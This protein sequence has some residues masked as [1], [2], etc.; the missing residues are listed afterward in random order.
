MKDM[1]KTFEYI[2]TKSGPVTPARG[3]SVEMM[4]GTLGPVGDQTKEDFDHRTYENRSLLMKKNY[5]SMKDI[6]LKFLTEATSSTPYNGGIRIRLDGIDFNE[7]SMHGEFECD[8]HH[9]V[10]NMKYPNAK[11]NGEITVELALD[12][13]ANT[14]IDV[15][16]ESD[17]FRTNFSQFIFRQAKDLVAQEAERERKESIYGG[18]VIKTPGNDFNDTLGI[19]NSD[20]NNITAYES[21]DWRLHKLRGLC[22]MCAMM[23]AGMDGGNGGDFG[24]DD[25]AAPPEGGDAGMGAPQNPPMGGDGSEA[26]QNA[27]EINGVSG[28]NGKG[29]NKIEFRD[30]A[31]TQLSQ[32]ALDN[33]AQIVSDGLSDI[34]DEGTSGAKPSPDEWYDGFPGVK[35]MTA[36]EIVEQFLSFQDYKAL[37]EQPLPEKGLQ[38]FAKALEGSK[39][40]VS[41]IKTNLGKWFPEVYNSDGTAMHDTAKEAASTIFP[42]DDKTGVGGGLSPDATVDLNNPGE[43]GDMM[44]NAQSQFGKASENLTDPGVDMNETGAMMPGGSGEQDKT[45]FALG[46]LNNIF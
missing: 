16:P 33:L 36:D 27:G 13:G 38:E 8:G 46:G 23:E 10:M 41:Q 26:P 39:V 4:K 34:T 40:D 28:G 22:D 7:T 30:F 37:G 5:L 35:N 45:D 32:A 12:N 42:S 44:D 9:V 21:V 17:Q 43:M 1:L 6:G 3:A 11:G 15:S 14:F 2:T 20:T 29:D 19:A 18:E 31:E 24:A 25:F